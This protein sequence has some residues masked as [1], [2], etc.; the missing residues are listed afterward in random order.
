MSE[1][2]QIE[3]WAMRQSRTFS[4]WCNMHLA[5]KGFEDRAAAEGEDFAKSFS[6]SVLILKLMNALY[7]VPLPKKY[8]KNPTTRVKCL[9]NANLGMR[10]IEKAEIK[11]TGLN[12]NNVLDGRFKM[13]M[14][15]VWNI[16]LDY[17][18][19]GISV[20]DQNAKQGLLIWCRK[21]TKDYKGINGNINNFTKDWK[22]GNAFLALVDKH[23]S[24]M[25]D[26]EGMYDQPAEEKLDAAFT[27][28]EELGIPRLLEISDLTEVAVPDDKAVMTYVS[29]LFKLFSKEDVKDTARSHVS[30]FLKFQ[31]RIAVLTKDYEDKASELLAWIE[32]KRGYFADAEQPADEVQCTFLSQEFKEYLMQEKPAKIASMIDALDLYSNIQGELKVNGRVPYVPPEGLEPELLQ[33]QVTALGESEKAYIDMIRDVR[34]SLVEKIEVGVI[35]DEMRADWDKAYTTFDRDQSGSLSIDEYKA[36]LSAVG[37][38]LS[39]EDFTAN[40]QAQAVDGFVAKEQFIS[41]LEAF[42]STEDTAES[43]TRSCNMLGDPSTTDFDMSDLGLSEEDLEYLSSQM[44]EEDTLADYIAA[45]FA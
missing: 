20:E 43:I 44:G 5:K 12:K 31:R 24:N 45:V 23:T 15:M 21:K 33:N 10:A 39:D 3:D 38:S 8:H 17:N 29:E 7:D 19:K 9:D 37:I 18:I 40:F 36:A 26:Y 13:M 4:K 34:S 35:S 16:I 41:Y 14:G 11:M 42:Y 30:Q 32:E 22:N 25:V 27:A 6:T 28:C 2:E 1:S